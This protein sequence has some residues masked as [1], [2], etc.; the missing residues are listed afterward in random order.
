M[1]SIL[2]LAAAAVPA[3]AAAQTTAPAAPAAGQAAPA[4]T[5]APTVGATVSDQAGVA[6][7][8]VVTVA[9]EA[10]VI[11][12]GTNKVPVPPS[13]I[14]SNAKGLYMAMTKA[15]LDAAAA[16]A[17]AQAAAALTTGAAVK[18]SDGQQLGTIKAADAQFVTVTTATGDVRL[19]ANAFGT[20]PDG[21]KIGLT[22]A[23][24]T[25]AVSAAVPAASASGSTAAGSTSSTAGASAGTSAAPGASAT[26][27]GDTTAPSGK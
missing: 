5:T 26:T 20:G 12:T 8:T 22:A 14:G 11:D 4:A 1:R 21:V 16:Q 3:L 10:V 9:P 19:P 15:Q 18:S 27:T 6:V 2:F 24:F 13:A 23:Q 7:G 25:Q 17:K